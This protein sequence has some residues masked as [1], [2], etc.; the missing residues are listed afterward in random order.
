MGPVSTL[1]L[2]VNEN[3][4]IEINRVLAEPIGRQTCKCS[5]ELGCKQW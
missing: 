3:V 4:E 1:L 2:P 5:H